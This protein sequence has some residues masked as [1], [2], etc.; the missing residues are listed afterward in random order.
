MVVVGAPKIEPSKLLISPPASCRSWA[1]EFNRCQAA[2]VET[3]LQAS[4]VNWS[5]FLPPRGTFSA[6]TRFL[7]APAGRGTSSSGIST[8]GI[9]LQRLR[10]KFKM[11]RDRI[12]RLWDWL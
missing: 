4:E 3:L 5:G 11:R 7:Q 8:T 6:S 10:V 1:V 9:R 2:M 12:Q